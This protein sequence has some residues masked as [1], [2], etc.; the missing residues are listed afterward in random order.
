MCKKLSASVSAW[1]RQF[2]FASGSL[3]RTIHIY[4]WPQTEA[5]RQIRIYWQCGLNDAIFIRVKMATG[6]FAGLM[7][8][9]FFCN[10]F[11]TSQAIKPLSGYWKVSII[12]TIRWK[13]HWHTWPPWLMTSK[14]ST[15]DRNQR[16]ILGH[17]NSF[18]CFIFGNFCVKWDIMC[19]RCPPL[20][21]STNCQHKTGKK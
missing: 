17:W 13:R 8:K 20:T 12:F 7:I 4:R 21:Q 16:L 11:P 1:K 6:N 19:S 18:E 3:F 2:T 15:Q 14:N 9:S 5:D 10:H